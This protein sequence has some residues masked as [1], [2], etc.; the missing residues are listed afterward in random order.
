M[1]T[2]G[3]Q[4]NVSVYIWLYGYTSASAVS[5][6][7]SQESHDRIS[8]AKVLMFRPRLTEVNLE[9]AIEPLLVLQMSKLPTPPGRFESKKSSRPPWRMDGRVDRER[10]GR[11]VG[12]PSAGY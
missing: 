7:A 11:G 12:A 3:L 10:P 6:V 5:S 2:N 4:I 1:P 9:S 8:F